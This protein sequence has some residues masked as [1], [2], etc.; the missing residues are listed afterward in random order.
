MVSNECLGDRKLPYLAVTN[1]FQKCHK[2][3]SKVSHCATYFY[4]LVAGLRKKFKNLKKCDT[5][6]AQCD[7]FVPLLKPLKALGHKGLRGFVTVVPPFL[8]TFTEIKK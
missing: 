6:L 8:K 1:I 2:T 3:D 5:L 7:T 4:Q